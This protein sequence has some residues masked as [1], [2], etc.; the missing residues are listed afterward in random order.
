MPNPFSAESAHRALKRKHSKTGGKKKQSGEINFP[1]PFF[2]WGHIGLRFEGA[3]CGHLRAPC[4]FIHTTH[5]PRRSL[6]SETPLTTQEILGHFGRGGSSFGWPGRLDWSHIWL[7]IWLLGVQLCWVAGAGAV[8]LNTNSKSLRLRTGGG[9]E[10]QKAPVV[11]RGKAQARRL[12]EA[13]RGSPRPH[14]A[15]LRLFREPL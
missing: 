8:P 3:R 9:S 6:L 4:Y 1:G 12:T 5:H 13:K 15:R 7:C 10:K 14:A 11:G 2:G